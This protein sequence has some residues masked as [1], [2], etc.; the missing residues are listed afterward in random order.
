MAPFG[1]SESL[2]AQ[3]RIDAIRSLLRGVSNQGDVEMRFLAGSVI[4]EEGQPNDELLILIEGEAKLVKQMEDGETVEVDAFPTGSILGI[5]SFWSRQPVFA[6]I[7][8][9][10]DAVCLSIS[11]ERWNAVI[12]RETDLMISMQALF[13][14]N[15]SNRYRNMIQSHVERHRLSREL[16]R[17]RNHLKDTLLKLEQLTKRLVNQEKLATMGQL[18]A[19]IAH[20]INNPV[21]ALT[22]NIA[23]ASGA[24]TTICSSG[25][26][27]ENETA[28]LMEGLC[29]PF[30]QTDE[31]RRRIEN[32]MTRYPKLKRSDARRL[33]QLTDRAMDVV[34]KIMKKPELRDRYLAIYELGNCLRSAS[35]SSTRIETIVR[36][37][38]NYG[39]QIGDSWDESDIRQGIEDTLTV[40]S[41]RMK[42]YEMALDLQ[43][44]PL[45][46]CNLGEINQ[47][48]TNLLANAMDATAIHGKIRVSCV[49]KEGEIVVQ[50]E[51]SGTGI[52]E[53]KRERIFEANYTTKNQ[54]GSYGLGLGLS[55]SKDIVEKHNGT[56]I[57]GESPL[58]GAR[59]VVSLPLGDD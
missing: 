55:I 29:C 11:R 34:H 21:G 50:V 53:E 37:L 28:V 12:L 58:G 18:V 32:L 35:I 2:G 47:V 3:N 23:M 46:S 51:D 38:K 15:L 33:A 8:A 36:G 26:D 43:D 48:W 24:L 20:E 44:C 41:N 40:L 27:S 39:R 22:R 4:L 57:A 31:K 42:N 19:G 14:S 49:E 45:L 6:R 16:E 56:V 13:V 25:K 17:E 5:T 52:P 1:E 30:W 9:I 7:E 59:F 54:S 10:E